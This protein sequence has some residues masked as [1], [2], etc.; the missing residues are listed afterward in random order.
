[1]PQWE[2][3]WSSLNAAGIVVAFKQYLREHHYTNSAL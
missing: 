1:M 2:H 3:N